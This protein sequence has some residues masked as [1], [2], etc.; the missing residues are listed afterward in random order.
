MLMYGP[1]VVFPV[2][3][4]CPTVSSFREHGHPVIMFLEMGLLELDPTAN[5]EESG[6]KKDI[7]EIL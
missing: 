6:F 4:I 5:K 7:I 2:S 1:I 3:I